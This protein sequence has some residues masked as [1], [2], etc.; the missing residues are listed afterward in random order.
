[1]EEEILPKSIEQRNIIKFLAIEGVPSNEIHTRLQ[2]QF[3]EDCLKETV[4]DSWAKTYILNRNSSISGGVVGVNNST[5]G[6]NETIVKTPYSR[7]VLMNIRQYVNSDPFVSLDRMSESTGMRKD[8]L[9]D[10]LHQLNYKRQNGSWIQND[11]VRTSNV[12]W[13]RKPICTCNLFG[14]GG[15]AAKQSNSASCSK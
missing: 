4:V 11:S 13:T 7:N 6:N 14:G 10:I 2:K 3:G 8:V 15:G 12:S 5:I 9:A 1:M